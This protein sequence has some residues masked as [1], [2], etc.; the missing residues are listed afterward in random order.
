MAQSNWYSK[1]IIESKQNK[2]RIMWFIRYSNR[3]N[4]LLATKFFFLTSP[5]SR[6]NPPPPPPLKQFS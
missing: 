6:S 1:K 4:I 3:N 2:I 5:R